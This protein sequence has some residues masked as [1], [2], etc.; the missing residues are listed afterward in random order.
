MPVSARV[1]A[2]CRPFLERLERRDVPSHVPVLIVPGQPASLPTGVDNPL[3][4]PALLSDFGLH[5]GAPPQQLT[6]TFDLKYLGIRSPYLDL[7]NSFIARGYRPGVDLFMAAHDWRMPVAPED[8]V[9]DGHLSKVTSALI[10]Q[11]KTFQFGVQYVG[12]WLKQVNATWVRTHPGEPCPGVDIIAHSEGYLLA[13]AYVSSPAYGATYT[14]SPGHAARLPRVLH[15]VGLAGPNEGA[16]EVFNWWN[17]NYLGA[18]GGSLAEGGLYNLLEPIY[19]GV[20]NL[21]WTVAG[22]DGKPLITRASVTGRTTHQPDPVRFLRAYIPSFRDELPT[23]AFLDGHRV[24]GIPQFRNDL[25][26]DLNAG[27]RNAWLNRVGQADAVFGTGLPTPT[28]VSPHTAVGRV[29]PLTSSAPVLA[30][31]LLVGAVTSRLGDVRYVDRYVSGGD[32]QAPL[33]SLVST[34]AGDPRIAIKKLPGISHSGVLT[35]PAV[36]SFLFDILNSSA[37]RRPEGGALAHAG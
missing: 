20:V 25:L 17:N 34:F 2:T 35:T 16:S 15:F 14:V 11:N 28:N 23:Y 32:S 1:A 12:Y 7:Y 33:P 3:A 26:L 31:E 36:Q 4:A 30:T 21:G 22:P 29:L 13:R 8:G 27:P 10:T 6:A 18:N 9:R 37:S 5:L 24:N 19:F